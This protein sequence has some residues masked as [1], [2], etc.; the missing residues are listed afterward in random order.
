MVDEGGTHGGCSQRLAPHPRAHLSTLDAAR[1]GA[2]AE[3]RFVPAGASQGPGVGGS[4]GTAPLIGK[5]RRVVTLVREQ[6][7][8]G[9]VAPDGR[10]FNELAALAVTDPKVAGG[11]RSY[12][13]DYPARAVIAKQ[14]GWARDQGSGE[15]RLRY[16]S[17]LFAPGVI[18]LQEAPSGDVIVFLP[19]NMTG[20]SQVMDRGGHP[21]EMIGVADS[22][23]MGLAC[24]DWALQGDRR[25][26]GLYPGLE[27]LHSAEREY[28]RLLPALGTCLWREMVAELEFALAEIAGRLE[29]GRSL[30]IVGWSM[31]A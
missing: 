1:A 12:L 8:V 23:G 25:E 22:L 19:G 20:A 14:G 15:W 17:S 30:H 11:A 26:K 31:G 2:T 4:R 7:L 24:W 6:W 5:L 27:S 3:R 28:S 21:H 9:R 16:S 18:R 10:I 13:T 29:A